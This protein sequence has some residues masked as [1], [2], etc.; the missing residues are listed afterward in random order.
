MVA[1]I[2][3][4]GAMSRIELTAAS[5]VLGKVDGQDVAQLLRRSA[6]LKIVSLQ[7]RALLRWSVITAFEWGKKKELTQTNHI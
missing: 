3:S 1:Q 4:A 2:P 5:S 7:G 6:P